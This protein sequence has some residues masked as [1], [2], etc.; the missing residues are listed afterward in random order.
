MSI[1]YTPEMYKEGYRGIYSGYRLMGMTHTDADRETL[2]GLFPRYDTERMAEDYKTTI[3]EMETI[4]ERCLHLEYILFDYAEYCDGPIPK[5][6]ISWVQRTRFIRSQDPKGYEEIYNKMIDL[7]MTKQQA[8]AVSVRLINP[9][10]REDQIKKMGVS[11]DEYEKILGTALKRYYNAGKN[12]WFKARSAKRTWY[13]K[14]GEI[15]LPM[16]PKGTGLLTGFAVNVE[17]K[18]CGCK[19]EFVYLTLKGGRTKK[20][21]DCVEV[22]WGYID[23]EVACP[24]CVKKLK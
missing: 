14:D 16:P 20:I 19:S 23:E 24:K 21:D 7:G 12:N 1:L 13:P 15:V 9:T 11:E 22:G 6:N 2:H 17:C 4:R 10:G 18:Y 5:D 3:R 8:E